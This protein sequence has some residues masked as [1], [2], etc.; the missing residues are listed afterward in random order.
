M[1]IMN[2]RTNDP[3][4]PQD[5][6]FR[7]CSPEYLTFISRISGDYDTDKAV[8]DVAIRELP[9]VARLMK[10]GH[11]LI[12][13]DAPATSLAPDG[14]RSET[15]LYDDPEGYD[16]TQEIRCHYRTGEN[17]SFAVVV[18]PKAGTVWDEQETTEIEFL[19][20]N[21]YHLFG[22]ARISM[23]LTR[24]ITMDYMTGVLNSAGL[25]RAGARLKAQGRLK[26]YVGVFF[27]LKNF[28]LINQKVGQR[29]G[30][31]IMVSFCKEIR[32]HLLPGE[33]MARPGGDNF[34]LLL[35][36]SHAE[37]VLAQLHEV[38]VPVVTPIQSLRYPVS[39]H[40]GIYDITEDDEMSGIMD[41]CTIALNIVKHSGKA[42]D[43]LWYHPSMRVELMRE[44]QVSQLFPYALQARE[45]IVY[46]QPKVDLETGALCGAEALVRWDHDG[47]I[48]PPMRFIPTLEKEGT[49]C[50]LDFYVFENVCRTLREWLDA[51]IEPVRVSVNFS[52]LHLYDSEL[53]DKIVSIMERYGIE[54]RYIEVELTEMS[55]TKNHDAMLDFLDRMRAH[56]IATSVDDFGTGYSSLN[57]LREFRMDIIKLD[58]SF[59]DRI[60]GTDPDQQTDEI[61]IGNIVRTAQELHRR[62]ITEG[63]ETPL[64]AAFLRSVHCDMAQGYLF[65]EPLPRNVFEDRLRG[66]RIYPLHNE[67]A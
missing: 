31:Q 50:K 14:Q 19:S 67:K 63:V 66:D 9:P 45:F 10:I 26:D 12:L 60:T 52:Q 3:Q 15:V 47:E 44:K 65:D 41:S 57:M 62:I 4:G 23:L 32:G 35:L 11:M 43:Q 36:K 13:L 55:G 59:I 64:Q 24:A 39:T 17:G 1:D 53:A 20:G 21:L 51:G 46:Y 38:F 22:R 18:Y 42:L 54:S 16:A 5:R 28:K 58:K 49:I 40:V 37:D 29:M 7:L 30:D 33:L 61:L 56:G 27:N 2:D 48:V 8:C 6:T 25:M 34:F